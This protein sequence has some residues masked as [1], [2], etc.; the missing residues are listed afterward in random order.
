MQYFFKRNIYL[1]IFVSISHVITA[2]VVTPDPVFPQANDSV[3]IIFHATEGTGGLA[4]FTGDV[5]AHTGV[6]TQASTSPGDWKYVKTGWGTNTPETKLQ[7]IGLNL[8][9]L[10]IKPDIRTYYGVPAGEKILQMAF[11]FRSAAEVGGSYLEG[12]DEGGA[13]IF[14]TVYEPG[15][16]IAL[17]KPQF[18]FQIIGPADTS[19]LKSHCISA[20]SMAM[21]VNGDWIA[22]TTGNLLQYELIPASTGLIDI[23]AVAYSGSS[24]VSDSM[25]IFV[26]GPVQIV[27]LPAGIREGINILNPNEVILCLYAPMKNHVFA[28]GDFN[29]WQPDSS[30]YMRKTPDGNHYWTH[31]HNLDPWR[32]YIFQYLVDG[33]IRIGDPYAEKVSD[34]WNDGYIPHPWV[35]PYPADKTR[36]IATVFTT[37]PQ[38]YNWQNQQFTPPAK[39]KLF[40]YE[41]LVRD[42]TSA[43]TFQAI[44]DTLPYLQR[45][46]VNAIELMPVNEFE[47]NSSWGYN[48]NYY[49]AVDK[50]YGTKNHLK[51][52]IDTCHQRGIAVILDL[53]YNH[54]FGT[55]PYVMLYWDGALNRPA[56]NSPF[57]NMIEKHDFNVGFD[58]NHESQ[59]TKKYISRALKFWLEEFRVDG[60]RFD[61]SK[62]FTQKNT[63]GNVSAWGQYDASR[64]AILKAYADTVWSVNPDAYVILEHFAENT[65]EKALSDMGMMLWGN[66]NYQYTE[67]AMGYHGSGKSDFSSID[68]LKRGWSA[69]HLIGYMESHDE[70]R[71]IYKCLQWGNKTAF[72]DI[73]KLDT[74]LQRGQL[75]AAFFFTIPGPKMIWQ[76]GELGYDYTIDHNGRTGEKPVRWDYYSVP[77]RKNLYNLYAGLA[78]LRAENELFQTAQPE[79]NL[80]GAIKRI[81]LKSAGLNAVVI[82]NFGVETASAAP[83][84]PTTG[85]WYDY[86]SGDSL[87]MTDQA[88]QITL[89]PGQ[90]HIFLDQRRIPPYPVSPSWK[91]QPKI[92][93]GIAYVYPNPSPGNLNLMLNTGS[94]SP[95]D[96]LIE[97][98]D[99]TGRLVSSATLSVKGQEV[100]SLSDIGTTLNTGIYLFRFTYGKISEITK[101]VVY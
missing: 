28:L 74:A 37:T 64:V 3:N 5:Y 31:L 85:I 16:N 52:L 59:A 33:E 60:F 26:R 47:G 73:T 2:Q 75:S 84:F 13:D 34:P 40:I 61:L 101:V 68:F 50:Y 20:D 82:G 56:A 30:A 19:V 23:K 48:P 6:I 29:Q 43:R 9:R 58:F 93:P 91:F 76:F 11:V 39:E 35:L 41:L 25:I 66:L 90:Y 12:K 17:Q 96:I 63:L 77:E 21:F 79:L 38:E 94:E 67:A 92:P 53:V 49:F 27:P 45:L 1:L 72:Y 83:F 88:M 22:S 65:E 89:E 71:M 98:F 7:K 57:Y 18:G 97:V 4:N 87:E 32:E 80:A 15:L 8:Y 44:I 86:F 55:S 69:P 46:G 100:I 99:P 14:V 51:A 42:F 78:S 36:G 54:S 70:E 95:G 81:G 10:S 62:G 24:T